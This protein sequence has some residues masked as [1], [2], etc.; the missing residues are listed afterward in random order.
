MIAATFRKS[1]GLALLFSLSIFAANAQKLYQVLPDTEENKFYMGIFTAADVKADTSF[2]WY[3][4]ALKYYR[5]NKE[6]VEAFKAK[7]GKFQL[8]LFAGTWCH[9]SQAI[10]PKYNACAEAAGLADSVITIIGTDRNKTTLANL[11]KVFNVTL[12]PTMIVMQAGKEVG[13]ITEYGNTGMPD[14]ELA[15]LIGKLD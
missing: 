7:A 4:E 15:A 3:A 2:K 9:D 12:V 1:F 8:V 10:F 11:H 6:L 13:R 5:P 14:A